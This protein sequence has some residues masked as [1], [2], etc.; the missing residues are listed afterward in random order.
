[1]GEASELAKF[2]LGE[3]NVVKTEVLVEREV[4]KKTGQE[5]IHILS[6]DGKPIYTFWHNPNKDPRPTPETVVE[7]PVVE[8]PKSM[9]G[10][11]P[12]AMLMLQN[13]EKLKE[14][15]MPNFEE[16]LGTLVR[17]S[18]NVEWSTGRLINKRS[19]KQLKY[20]ELIKLVSFSARKCDKLIG[21]MKEYNLLSNT[22]EGYFISRDLIKKG[23]R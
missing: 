8:K 15:N 12:Y 3:N 5:F 4:N 19:K 1:M 9:G 2:L 13:V 7:E 14:Q 16:I 20:G 23:G 18:N 22:S 17:L 10:K 21:I 11:K 6:A